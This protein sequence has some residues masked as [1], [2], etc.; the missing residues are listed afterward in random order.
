MANAKTPRRRFTRKTIVALLLLLA[1]VGG[2]AWDGSPLGSLALRQAV[3]LKFREVRQVSPT[4]LVQW[5]Q[6]PNR[7][8]PLLVDA[9]PTAAFARSHIQGAVNIDPAQPDLAPLAHV[10][11]DQPIVVYD[12]PGVV[13]AAMVVGMSQAEFTR[14]SSLEGGLFRWVNEGHPIVDSAGPA[15]TVEPAARR[16]SVHVVRIVPDVGGQRFVRDECTQLL[17]GLEDRHRPGGHFHR[18]AGS[19]IPG[20]AGLPPSD[21]EGP[22]AAHLDVVLVLKGFLDRVE[23]GVHDAGAVLLR[24]HGPRGPGNGL[25]HPFDEIG[26]GHLSPGGLHAEHPGSGAGMLETLGP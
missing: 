21:L 18:I 16:T 12:G 8:P 5:T 20:H 26:L 1:V 13:S 3:R 6:D 4:E 2:V 23:K 24:D 25:R 10:P 19:G 9:R 11:R 17:A 14:L 7:P 15:T 22:E